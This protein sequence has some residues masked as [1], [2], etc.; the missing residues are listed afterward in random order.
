M[1]PMVGTLEKIRRF[2]AVC[3]EIRASLDVFKIPLGIMV[4]VPVAVFLAEEYAPEV[5]FF[6]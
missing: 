6:F 3:E 1:F 2:R 5:D 4:E